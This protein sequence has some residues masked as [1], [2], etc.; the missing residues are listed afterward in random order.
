MEQA[1][2]L[3]V[4]LL[5]SWALTGLARRYA[6]RNALIDHPNARSS[7]VRATPRGG[8]AAI[9][10]ASLGAMAIAAAVGWLEVRLALA[11]V[12]GGAAIALV[13]WIDDHGHVHAGVRAAIHFGAAAWAVGVLG[14]LPAL[15]LGSEEL[16]L[17]F[18]GSA[19]AVL[20]IVWLTNLYNFMDGIDGIAGAEAVSVGGIAAL[21]LWLGGSSGLAL[22]AAVVAVSAAGFLVWNWAPARIFM[23]DVG[24]GLLG[25]LFGVLAVA[26]ERQGAVPLMAW[27]LLLGVFVMDAT[28]TLFRRVLRGDRWYSA[29]RDHAYQRATRAGHSHARVTTAVLA[30][31]VGLGGAAALAAALPRVAPAVLI[32]GYVLLAAAYVTIESWV[33]LGRHRIKEARGRTRAAGAAAPAVRV[34]IFGGSFDP[35]HLGHLIVAQDAFARLRLDRVLWMPAAL[36]PHKRDREVT[37]PSVRLEMVRAAVSGDERFEVSDAEARRPGPSWTVETLRGLEGYQKGSEL[38]LLLGADQYRE[39]HT[40]RE[41]DAI[42]RMAR[43]VVLSREGEVGDDGPTASVAHRRQPVTRID[44]SSTAIRDRVARG[45]PIRYLVRPEVEAIIRRENLYREDQAP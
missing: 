2:L 32:A 21:L 43:L 26:S 17:G 18:A 15:S 34:G 25:F 5:C 41:P 44:I 4:C 22:G 37:P 38:V 9:A 31:N 27:L 42:A 23:G 14:G 10:A 24:S 6:L 33:P 16:Q 13:G 8:G 1:A 36:P 12:G 45:E 35:P 30:L 11:L 19:A 3:G 28:I 39:F 29:H 40:W 7:H 20:G